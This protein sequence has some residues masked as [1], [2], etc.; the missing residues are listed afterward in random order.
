M[1]MPRLVHPPHTL[2]TL[3]CPTGSYDPAQRLM[4]T[5]VGRLPLGPQT[6]PHGLL[7]YRELREADAF[8]PVRVPHRLPQGP[9][10]GAGLTPQRVLDGLGPLFLQLIELI[11]RPLI[12]E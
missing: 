4:P 5:C 9:Q 12:T 6:L 2:D 8:C 3:D 10:A 11:Q 1:A 7:Q